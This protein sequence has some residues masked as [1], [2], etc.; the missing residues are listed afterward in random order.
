MEETTLLILLAI[1]LFWYT[2]MKAKERG[3]SL[4]RQSCREMDHQ[5]L[6]DAVVLSY[7]GLKRDGEGRFRV[8]RIYLFRY[9]DHQ[10][11]IFQG[12]LILLGYR[13]ESLLLES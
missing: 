8:R 9:L 7:M 1:G 2:S 3:L 4:A 6:D 12:T 10:G 13:L 5:L 11:E